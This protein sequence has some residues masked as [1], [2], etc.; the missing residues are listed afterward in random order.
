MTEKRN[1]LSGLPQAQAWAN[2]LVMRE[3]KTP[4]DLINSMHRLERRYGIS[5]RIFFNLR[6]RPP[7]DVLVGV[8]RQLHAAYQH[9]CERQERLLQ[10]EKAVTEAKVLALEA[11]AGTLPDENG[12]EGSK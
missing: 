8:Y 9:E 7:S 1:A 2:A 11:L 3:M 4:G 6:Y 12:G 10:H 5:W